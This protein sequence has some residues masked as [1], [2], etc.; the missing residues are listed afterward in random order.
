MKSILLVLTYIVSIIAH[1]WLEVPAPRIAQASQTFPC[2]SATANPTPTQ[3]NIGSALTATWTHFHTGGAV[4]LTIFNTKDTL[5]K[6]LAVGSITPV[7][8]YVYQYD[9]VS[10]TIPQFGYSGGKQYITTPGLYT[11]Q[12]WWN[13]Y[14][15]CADLNVQ[16]AL[17]SGATP[18]GGGKYAISGGTYD[19]TTGIAT[20]D[21]GYTQSSNQ[22]SC[23]PSGLSGGA[24][25]GIILLVI[26]LLVIGAVV[27]LLMFWKVKRPEKWAA[28]KAK[29]SNK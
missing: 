24:I 16:A 14:Y 9:D 4:N 25:F 18:L 29:V 28:L 1:S 21:S 27:G 5:S 20:C 19:S 15:S 11:M 3:T 6:S 7:V 17:P 10:D 23:V 13:G 22:Q 12:W 2:E 26:V 8:T